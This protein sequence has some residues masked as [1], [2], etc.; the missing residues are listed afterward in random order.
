MSITSDHPTSVDSGSILERYESV[1][2]SLI[3]GDAGCFEFIRLGNPTTFYLARRMRFALHDLGVLDAL[4][5]TWVTPTADG[6]RFGALSLQQADQL[7]LAFE[8]MA[9]GQRP[10]GL[11]P[12]RLSQRRRD[13]R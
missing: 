9:Q 2:N 10:H 8:D 13:E 12:Q 4:P 5:G 11:S 6:L 7:V 3:R 1:L